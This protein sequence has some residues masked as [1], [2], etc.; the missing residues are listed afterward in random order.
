MIQAVLLW[1]RI[2]WLFI[3]LNELVESHTI[4]PVLTAFDPLG[5]E[6]TSLSLSVLDI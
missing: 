3:Q 5:S 1:N 2:H 6:N 4:T